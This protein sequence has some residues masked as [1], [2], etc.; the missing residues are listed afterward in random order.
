MYKKEKQ[1]FFIKDSIKR[2]IFFIKD[3]IKLIFFKR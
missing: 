3:N 1:N 2:I